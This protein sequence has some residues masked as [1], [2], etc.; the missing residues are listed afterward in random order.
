MENNVKDVIDFRLELLNEASKRYY[1]DGFLPL[2]ARVCILEAV[3]DSL[4]QV[5]YKGT[6][7]GK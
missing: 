2:E 4:L 6:N 5:I 7:D 1:F 3:I